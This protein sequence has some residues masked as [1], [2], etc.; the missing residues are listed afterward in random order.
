MGWIIPHAI[1][2]L[3]RDHMVGV[4]SPAITVLLGRKNYMGF[5][6]HW[7]TIAVDESADPRDGT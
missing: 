3:S 2:D 6:Q 1:T 5:S 4:T 7:P